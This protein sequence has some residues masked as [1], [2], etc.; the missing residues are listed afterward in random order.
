MIL[1]TQ[2]GHMVRD[3]APPFAQFATASLSLGRRG[4]DAPPH[5]EGLG[6]HPEERAQ[7]SDSKTVANEARVSKDEAPQTN[8]NAE[9]FLPQP[10]GSR[11]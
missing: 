4:C 2:T 6:L 8:A 11:P 7:P 5:H 3:G 10:N 9:P 1:A